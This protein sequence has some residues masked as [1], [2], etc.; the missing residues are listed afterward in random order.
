MLS[1]THHGSSNAATYRCLLCDVDAVGD[2]ALYWRSIPDIH[3][4]PFL[5]PSLWTKAEFIC[6]LAQA[7]RRLQCSSI[8]QT[9]H[10]SAP[11][12]CSRSCRLHHACDSTAR[13]CC[14]LSRIFPS[15]SVLYHRKHFCAARKDSQS[16]DTTLC[17]AISSTLTQVLPGT[18]GV[19]PV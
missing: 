11:A 2:V 14:G 9:L 17:I 19:L 16:I 13:C 4:T 10:S 18:S 15:R 1:S 6:P 5:A 12:S 8:S 7:K 3:L